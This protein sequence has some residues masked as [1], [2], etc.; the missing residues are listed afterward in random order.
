MN[1][2]S[3]LHRQFPAYAF[4]PEQQVAVGQEGR[5]V[6][7]PPPVAESLADDGADAIRGYN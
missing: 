4:S 1:L 6:K 3:T 7:Y 5:A 2:L